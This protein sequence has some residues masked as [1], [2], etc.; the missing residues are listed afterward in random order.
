MANILHIDASPRG[1]RSISRALSYELITSWKETHLGVTVTYRDLGRSPV[2][3]VDE[4]WIAA[5]FTP[6]DARTPEL[7]EAIKLSDSLVDE[8]LAADR[9]VFGVPMYNLSIPSTFKAYIDQIVRAGKTFAVTENGYQGLVDSSKKVLIITSRGG[10]FPAGT[11]YEAYDHQV[12][13]LRT[14]LGF[15]GLTDVTFIHADSLNLGDEARQNSIAAAK[16]AI[17]QA[18]NSW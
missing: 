2:P 12:P 9:Y 18:V 15:M 14:I 17:A 13:Y 8:F 1:E 3:H 7:N 16:D 10:T 5:A 4:S 6:P 11:P